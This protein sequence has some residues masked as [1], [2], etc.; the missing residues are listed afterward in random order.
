[1]ANHGADQSKQDISKHND[2]SKKTS[3]EED[4]LEDAECSICCDSID[5]KKSDMRFIE[6]G[7]L[8]IFS[9]KHF[10]K[11]GNRLGGKI[12]YVEWAEEYSIEIESPLDFKFAE[13]IYIN[14]KQNA[15]NYRT[16]KIP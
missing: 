15:I 5:I 12:G 8:Y 4:I 16:K 7:S 9:C 6:N 13:Q 2:V 3:S 1:M 11:T 14:I 10:E